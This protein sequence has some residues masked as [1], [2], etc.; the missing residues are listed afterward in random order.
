[1][2]PHE[3]WSYRPYSPLL[4]DA[5]APYIA[6][7]VPGVH[8]IHIE[9]L[10]CEEGAEY[11]VLLALRGQTP[12]PVAKTRELQYDF[13]ELESDTDYCFCVKSASGQS[14]LRLART[15]ERDG[16]DGV[17]VNY[18]HPEDDAYVFSGR[19]L[20]SPSMVR[21]P[22]GALLASMD[23]FEANRPQ[24][25][26]LLFRS[27]DGGQSWHYACEL[28]PCF[29]GKLFVHRGRLY[30]LAV[31]TEYGDLLIGTSDDGGFSFTKPSV[32]WRGA[33]H[34]GASG[35]HKNP[36][37]VVEYAGRLWNSCEWG[38]WAIGGH[39]SMV[40]SCAADADLLDPENWRFT[41]PLPYDPAW[42]GVAEGPSPGTLEGCLTV[43]PDG[44][45]YNIMRYEMSKCQPDYGRVLAFRVNAQDPD[46][47]LSYSHAIELPGN[48]AKFEIQY[49]A[50]S[51]CYYSI[52]CR[53]RGSEHKYDRNLLSLMVSRDCKNWSLACDL[54]D[55]RD[56]DPKRVGFQYTDFLFDGDDLL[57]L[58]RTAE[59]CAHN[60]HDANYSVFHRLK[61]FRRFAQSAK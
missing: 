44:G 56:C 39:A 16:T 5:G 21:L 13:A 9:W 10:S 12:C 60:F 22:D 28:F 35:I 43:L 59:N 45:L 29:W 55:K 30:M 46:A 15:G 41:P 54:I 4:R 19:Y 48:H 50:Q 38:A 40:F 58:V 20:C 14:R 37:P 3:T 18:L 17:T 53:I 34:S 51:S 42:P 23:V 32:L 6:R 7:V 1:M 33:C 52:V 2:K 31:S 27:V 61:H 47:P 11:T 57:Y 8:S 26:T 25:L 49:D 24:N 36:Q